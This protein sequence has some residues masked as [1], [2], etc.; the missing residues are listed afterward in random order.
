MRGQN[1]AR[2]GEE[3]AAKYLE[4]QGY[5]VLERNWS[6]DAG[7]VSIVASDGDALCFIE[8]QTRFDTG[9]GF[10]SVADSKR[11][12]ER[13]ERIAVS[14]L[15]ENGERFYEDVL[16]RFDDISLLVLAEGR[17]FLRH[18]VNAFGAASD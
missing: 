16:I 3:A 5:H 18:F 7:E 12:R 11:K 9:R 8:V 6:C 4:H 15:R 2:R 13:F 17:A 14:Y 1:L 10:P